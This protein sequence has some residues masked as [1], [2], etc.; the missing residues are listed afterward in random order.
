MADSFG[1]DGTA[2][3][4]WQGL[5]KIRAWKIAG[6]GKVGGENRTKMSLMRR[7]RRI[8]FARNRVSGAGFAAAR[9]YAFG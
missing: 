1:C 2:R 6:C 8:I 9:R 7:L 3:E 5:C 4:T